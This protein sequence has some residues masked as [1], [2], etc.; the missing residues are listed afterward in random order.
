MRCA[1]VLD[2]AVFTLNRFFYPTDGCRRG[3]KTASMWRTHEHRLEDTIGT[4]NTRQQPSRF[5]TTLKERNSERLKENRA[6][7]KKGYPPKKHWKKGGNCFSPTVTSMLLHQI[8]SKSKSAAFG[9][10]PAHL[11]TIQSFFFPRDCIAGERE[12][13]KVGYEQVPLFGMH[14]R[15]YTPPSLLGLGSPPFW[16]VAKSCASEWLKN[17]AGGRLFQL[18]VVARRKD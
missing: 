2:A 15:G 8:D 18:V 14:T 11:P 10:L 17:T 16:H 1:G 12:W 13:S 6:F 4:T 9:E 5:N 3:K 7:D